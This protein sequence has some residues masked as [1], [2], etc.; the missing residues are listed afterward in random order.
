[1]FAAVSSG[2]SSL[3]QQKRIA[4][5][6]PTPS[7]QPSL[8]RKMSTATRNMFVDMGSSQEGSQTKDGKIETKF[9]TNSSLHK[10]KLKNVKT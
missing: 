4:A 7:K 5:S 1:M 8:Q 3:N 2:E 6:H 9:A 10:G